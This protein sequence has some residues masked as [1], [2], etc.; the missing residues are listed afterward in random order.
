MIITSFRLYLKQKPFI[1]ILTKKTFK[2]GQILH[3]ALNLL[4]LG[5]FAAY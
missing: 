1:E 4:D 3:L 2:L 5:E